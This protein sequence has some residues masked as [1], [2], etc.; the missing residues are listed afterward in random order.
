MEK[1]NID[2]IIIGGGP[3]GA[4]AAIYLARFNYRV[5]LI[6]SGNTIKGR[7]LM[8]TNLSNFLGHDHKVTG[9]E[10]LKHISNQ[11]NQLKVKIKNEEVDK[12]T[13]NLK[14]IFS[15]HTNKKN[16][17]KTKYL[18]LAIGFSDNMPQ[19][20]NL[21]LY[22]D[23]SVFHCML[24]DWYENRKKTITICSDK[25]DGLINAMRIK[26]YEPKSQINVVSS[27]EKHLYSLRLVNQAVSLGVKVYH[28][29]IKKIFGDNGVLREIELDDGIKVPT[30]I[31]F[32]RL[33]Q[34]RF[35]D[36]LAKGGLRPERDEA[37]WFRVDPR[38][39]E[40]SIKNLFAIGPIN[41]GPDQAII[42][43]GEGALAALEINERILA[44][45]K[46]I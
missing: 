23:K 27:I 11:L 24:C 10:F 38:T 17:Y 32:T 18:I 28:S 31:L 19:I 25:N 15:V 3:A 8:A 20:D 13:S 1:I 29:P 5:R 45:N 43:G 22:Y 30:E 41:D 39:F 12:V 46:I 40:T 36:F 37:G 44:D 6:D 42:A 2:P 35:D 26:F 21:E 34:I 14:G 4:S 9:E 33:G 16:I 7:T